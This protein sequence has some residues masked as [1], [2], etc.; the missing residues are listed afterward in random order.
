VPNSE[1]TIAEKKT[2][3]GPSSPENIVIT[4]AHALA[5]SNP[6]RK[7][8]QIYPRKNNKIG[9]TSKRWTKQQIRHVNRHNRWI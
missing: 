8:R 9:N 1:A 5:G 2:N 6:M 7:M 3:Y 4:T